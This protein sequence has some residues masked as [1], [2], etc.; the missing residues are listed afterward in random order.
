[1][2]SLDILQFMIS[3]PIVLLFQTLFE[4]VRDSSFSFTF[5]NVDSF[6]NNF[7]YMYMQV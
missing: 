2:Q 5:I 4:K 1:M 3:V 7:V 6:V